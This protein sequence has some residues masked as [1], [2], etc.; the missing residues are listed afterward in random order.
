MNRGHERQESRYWA[1]GV[2]ADLIA[3]YVKTGLADR[4]LAIQLGT[5]RF[6][7]GRIRG[8]IEQLKHWG[9][10]HDE[11]RNER[12]RSPKQVPKSA[13]SGKKTGLRRVK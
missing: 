13:L 8:V 4:E 3:E 7:K 9:N 1:H 12:P 2:I 5:D 11:R 6:A 10:Y